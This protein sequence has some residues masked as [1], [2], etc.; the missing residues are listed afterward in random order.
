MREILV[1]QG[2]HDFLYSRKLRVAHVILMECCCTYVVPVLAHAVLD[3]LVGVPLLLL[4][5]LERSN[6]LRNGDSGEGAG[7]NDGAAHDT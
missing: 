1:I 3:R 6:R 7:S 5:S 2:V 4:V